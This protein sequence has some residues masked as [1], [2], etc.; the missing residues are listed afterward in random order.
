MIDIA[1]EFNDESF[2]STLTLQA[3]K[4]VFNYEP[5]VKAVFEAAL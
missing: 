1:L 3:T 5:H 4:F 2:V